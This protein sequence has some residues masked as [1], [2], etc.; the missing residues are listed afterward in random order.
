MYKFDFDNPLCELVGV[1]NND[2]DMRVPL[3]CKIHPYPL[4][5][6]NIKYYNTY[7]SKE[8]AI[9]E[10]L[11]YTTKHENCVIN[12]VARPIDDGHGYAVK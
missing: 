7:L 9:K 3:E 12:D 2:Y 6:T 8:D 10:S 4:W 11:K 5:M 1:Y